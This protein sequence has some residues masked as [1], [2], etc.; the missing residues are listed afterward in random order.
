MKTRHPKFRTLIPAALIALSLVY[1]LTGVR[2]GLPSL[3]YPD[4][5]ETL[6]KIVIPMARNLDLNPHIFNKGSLFYYFLLA[7]F[8][9][10]FT[11]IK[12]FRLSAADY[13]GLVGR[14]ALIGRVAT[15]C[16]GAFGVWL[17]DRVAKRAA[18]GTAARLAAACLAVNTGYASYSHFAYM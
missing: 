3:W 8:S 7:V 15:A 4:E 9:P 6:E 2:W 13:E 18:G 10:Y 1:G 14:L 16:V 11:A 17:M 5:P 12:L